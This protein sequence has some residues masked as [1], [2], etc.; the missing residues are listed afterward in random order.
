MPYKV[1]KDEETGK[2]KLYNKEKKTYTKKMFAT[3]ESAMKMADRYTAFADSRK[4]KTK[5]EDLD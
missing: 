3:K 4:K 2:F 5:S 1:E